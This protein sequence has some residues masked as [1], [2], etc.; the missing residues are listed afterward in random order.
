MKRRDFV[1][2]GGAAAAW[3]FVAQAQQPVPVRRVGVL[4]TGSESDPKTQDDLKAFTQ[5]FQQLGWTEGRNV[6]IETR[7]TDSNSSR[8]A[9]AAV[10]LVR[11]ASDVILAGS[12]PGLAALRQ[13]T[14]T[15]PI[16][17][18]NVTDP[19]GQGFVASLA[20]PGGN[21]TGFSN[22]ERSMG[23]KWL[24][25]L[26]ELSPGLARVAVVFNPQASPQ[27]GFYVPAIEGA[28]RQFGIEPIVTRVH[29][30]SE[31]DRALAA[32]GMQANAGLIVPPAVS[33]D[34]F[35][36]FETMARY[37]VPAIYSNRVYAAEGGLVAYGSDERDLYRRAASYVDRILRGEKPADLPVQQPTKFELVINL[38][39]AKALG[40]SVPLALQASADEVI[41]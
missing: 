35:R 20:R 30:D 19:V 13:A 36:I 31:M 12:T 34:R 38:K 28:A 32:I 41:E 11:L 39:T 9:S 29:D 25:I 37:R 10:E 15:V 33:F 21:I 8:T 23:S 16:V 6:R 18:A 1:M 26:R 3:P 22:F 14:S 7:W 5:A 4:H 2:L 17:F 24:E 40:I 27:T